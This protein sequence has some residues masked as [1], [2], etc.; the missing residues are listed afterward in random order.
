VSADGESCVPEVLETDEFVYF[1]INDGLTS[2]S[3]ELVRCD[4]KGVLY[5]ECVS[6][7][8]LYGHEAELIDDI[9]EK[10]RAGMEKPDDS[11]H[12]VS[13]GSVVEIVVWLYSVVSGEGGTRIVDTVSG[14]GF[15]ET[16]Y[17]FQRQY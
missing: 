7:G 15:P 16:Q 11:G 1:R 10:E 12:D 14:T 6:K 13:A 17:L 2:S 3:K 5:R 9:V 4:T 8:A